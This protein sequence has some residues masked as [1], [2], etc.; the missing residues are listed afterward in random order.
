MNSSAMTQMVTLVENMM[1]LKDEETLVT[2]G[3]S[4]TLTGIKH[5]NLHGCHKPDRKICR[6]TLSYVSIIPVLHTNI[7][8][9]TQALNESFQVTPEGE[10]LILKKIPPRFALPR[11]WCTTAANDLY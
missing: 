8:T 3:D 5:G 6:V 4:R 11:K 10:A 1:N 9:V 7:F 2:V